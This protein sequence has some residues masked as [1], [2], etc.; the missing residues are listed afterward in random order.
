MLL[1]SKQFVD[2]L[3]IHPIF[4]F[5]LAIPLVQEEGMIYGDEFKKLFP[6]ITGKVGPLL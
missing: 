3:P 1:D 5:N 2:S 6:F 4:I